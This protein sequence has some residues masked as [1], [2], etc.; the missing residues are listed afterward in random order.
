MVRHRRRPPHKNRGDPQLEPRGV[1][2][3]QALPAAGPSRIAHEGLKRHASSIAA[4]S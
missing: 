1:S 3:P 4:P 2:E